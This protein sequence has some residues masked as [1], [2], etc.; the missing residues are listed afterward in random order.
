MK[1]RVTLLPPACR[2]VLAVMASLG[3]RPACTAPVNYDLDPNHTH[4]MFEVDHYGMS[5]WRGIFRH[6]YGTVTLDTAASTGTV[7]VTVDVASV[8]F[9]NDQMNNVAVNSTAPAILEAAKYPTAHYNGTLGGFVNGAPTTVTGTLTL[10]GVTRPL[11]LHVDIF[12]CIPIHPVLKREVCGADASGSF[13]R[14][15]FGITVGQKFGFK[16]DVTLRIQVEAIKTE[17]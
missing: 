15:A 8:D 12:K 6:T 4:P 17:P 10:H 14:A 9:G 13:D 5:M 2:M 1:W 3:A 11:T 16:M 7:D